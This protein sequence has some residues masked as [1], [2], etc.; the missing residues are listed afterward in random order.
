[1]FMKPDFLFAGHDTCLYLQAALLDCW[2]AR[3]TYFVLLVSSLEG[4]AICL[5]SSMQH[6]QSVMVLLAYKMAFV[7]R[8]EV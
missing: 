7:L 8:L 4:L 1:M 3:F 2:I 6:G 5:R